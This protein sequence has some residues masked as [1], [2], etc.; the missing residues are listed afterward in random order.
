M[1]QNYLAQNVA[2]QKKLFIAF[3]LTK[4]VL[5]NGIAANIARQHILT[6]MDL[7]V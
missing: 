1:K 6:G 3:E 4:V 5:P 2:H 7:K